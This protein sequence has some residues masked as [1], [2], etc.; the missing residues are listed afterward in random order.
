M[1]SFWGIQ[2]FNCLR[3]ST[4][5]L[6]LSKLVL[7][8]LVLTPSYGELAR[9]ETRCT[10]A[11]EFRKTHCRRAFKKNQISVTKKLNCGRSS[12][13]ASPSSCQPKKNT[14]AEMA[15]PPPLQR[16]CDVYIWQDCK[17]QRLSVLAPLSALK[18]CLISSQL[19]SPV[20]FPIALESRRA[21]HCRFMR[22]VFRLAVSLIRV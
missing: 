6:F 7:T 17:R 2:S 3:C 5:W 18:C 15:S 22:P 20:L 10:A 9:L 11:A 8:S 4:E 14:Q 16:P 1:I 12:T 21:T 13:G 19:A